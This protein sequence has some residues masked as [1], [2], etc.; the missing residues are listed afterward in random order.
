MF[1]QTAVQTAIREFG[2]DGWL[3]C[4]FRNSNLLAKR[5]LDMD[6][7]AILSRRWYYFIPAKGEPKKLVHRIEAGALDHLPGS[8]R[9]YLRW[10]EL[11]DGIKEI[12]TGG[13]NVAM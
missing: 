7:Q 5:I 3:L 6:E 12:L 1:N 8:K 9:V 10:Q 2:F 4:D 11:E 13:K